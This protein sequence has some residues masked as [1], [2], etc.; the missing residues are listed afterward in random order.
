[1]SKFKYVVGIYDDRDSIKNKELGDKYKELTEFFIRHMKYGIGREFLT[2][3]TVNEI[4]NEALSKNYEYCLLM[5]VGHFVNDPS[6]FKYIESW[7]DKIDFFVTGHIIDRESDNSQKN[8]KGHYWGLHKQC[9]IINLKYYE[10]FGKPHW[11]DKFISEEQIE[12]V[13]AKRSKNDIHDDYTPIFLEPTKETKVCTP[14]VDG[15]N[16]INKSLENGLTVYNFHPK[17]RVTKG[18]AYPNKDIDTLKTQLTWINDILVGAPNCVFLWNTENYR[19]IKVSEGPKIKKLYAVAAAFKPNFILNK[20]GFYDDTEIIYF[21]YSKQSLAFKK[22]LLEKW[23]GT[24]YPDFLKRMK[25]QYNINE[26]YGGNTQDKPYSEL[27]KNELLEWDSEEIIYEHW[28]RYK[29]LKHTF[30]HCDI[31]ENPEKLI[32][33]VDNTEDSYIWWSNA[34]H[35]VTAHY[36]RTLAD[37]KDHYNTNWINALKIKNENL[38]CFGTDIIHGKIINKNIK[39]CHFEGN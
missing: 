17:I 29:K 2:G 23:D 12:V 19:D 39:D 32:N 34:F 18:Y 25:K 30:I 31:L 22:L 24:N 14:Y 15:W 37:L 36:T 27:W 33:K 6:F 20:F 28:Q 11:G 9:M 4:L 7:I 1:M 16:F 38:I 13:K 21:D 5:S 35:T 8:S 10:E 26:T 3:T